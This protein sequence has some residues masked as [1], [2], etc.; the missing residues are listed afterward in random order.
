VRARI[1][2]T[3][4]EYEERGHGPVVLFLHAFPLGLSM[5][6]SQAAA[7]EATHRVVRFDDRGFGGS[8]PHQGPLTMDQIADDADGLLDALGIDRAA[9]CGCSMGGYAAF[10]MVRRHPDRIAAL[11]LQDTRS[12][13]DSDEARRGRADVAERVLREGAKAAADAY[14]PKLVGETTHRKRPELLARLRE[15]ILGTSPRGI[16]DALL[17]LGARADS[18]ATLAQIRVPTL[19]VCGVEDVLT[20]PSEAEAMHRAIPGS[21]LELVP[22]AGHLANLEN[23][24]AYNKALVAFLT[25][26]GG[27]GGWR[28]R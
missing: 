4:I 23:P 28:S 16:A 18:Q 17:G 13:A 5:W 25:A 24:D 6:D 19:L 14:L 22:E 9:V 1:G 10:A 20:P 7:L 21:R 12:G 8:P 27:N 2:E 26:V 15:T 3:E 11:V